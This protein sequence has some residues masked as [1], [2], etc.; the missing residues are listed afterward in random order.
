MVEILSTFDKKIF[1]G[2][3]GTEKFTAVTFT[4]D[5]TKAI[6]R[7]VSLFLFKPKDEETAELYMATKQV[8]KYVDFH[9]TELILVKRTKEGGYTE[10]DV[11][12]ARVLGLDRC[13]ECGE[14]F[15]NQNPAKHLV[16]KHGWS[17]DHA[18]VW[19][20]QNI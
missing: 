10:R 9:I 18:T 4:R 14:S 19:L 3:L 15:G 16:E 20:I 12:I 7:N 11:D 13:P 5:E 17:E 6:P 2:K 1:E 8:P